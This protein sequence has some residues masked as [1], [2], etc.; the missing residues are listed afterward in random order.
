MLVDKLFTW[1]SLASKEKNKVAVVFWLTKDTK[2]APKILLYA[3][4]TICLLTSV[5]RHFMKGTHWC[6]GHITKY[7]EIHPFFSSLFIKNA[8]TLVF[9]IFY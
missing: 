7:L 4:L 1:F 2:R 5:S 9:Q 3:Q 6:K 8:Q